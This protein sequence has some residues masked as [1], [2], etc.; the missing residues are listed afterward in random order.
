MLRSLLVSDLD[1]TL[2]DSNKQVSAFSARIL[3][4]F[5]SCGGLFT[6][7]TARMV[8]GCQDRLSEL[9]L[10]LPWIVMNGAALYSPLTRTYEHYFSVDPNDVDRLATIIEQTQAGAFVYA[11]NDGRLIIGY[12]RKRDLE[13]TQYNSRAAREANVSISNIGYS[14][15]SALGNV[16]YFAVVGTNEQL[17]L[18]ATSVP[19]LSGL[20]AFP[21]KNV[22]NDTDCLEIASSK[23]G[24]DNA[25]RLLSRGLDAQEL[26]VFGDNHNDLE[27]MRIAD[28]ALAPQGAE[29]EAVAEAHR[30][31]KS[32]DD[33]G[34]ARE[35]E[36]R[37]L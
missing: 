15:W 21:Y 12:A 35:I 37:F 7:A 10:Q 13:W 32:N 34:V 19:S 30:T 20:R 26:I 33:D 29:P 5:I 9:D 4:K 8:Y 6:V 36:R 24:K 17:A 23:A 31:I 27:M 22:Y 2:L 14:N 3:N 18:I 11:I 28:V 1:G 25:V 16:V